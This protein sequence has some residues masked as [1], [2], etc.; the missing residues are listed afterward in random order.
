MI[1]VLFYSHV[2]TAR[3]SISEFHYVQTKFVS[4]FMLQSKTKYRIRTKT[5]LKLNQIKK[6]MSRPDLLHIF[7]DYRV[8][9][10]AVLDISQMEYLSDVWMLRHWLKF[11][12]HVPIHFINLVNIYPSVHKKIKLCSFMDVVGNNNI[13]WTLL[14]R[15]ETHTFSFWVFSTTKNWL[16]PSMLDYDITRCIYLFFFNLKRTF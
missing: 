8:L 12:S 1:A 13:R 9:F 10:L 4:N 3:F 11:V 14:F 5:R 2:V 7:S 16:L 6:I 15:L